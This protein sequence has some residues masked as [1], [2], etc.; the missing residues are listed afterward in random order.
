MNRP[1]VTSDDPGHYKQQQQQ[2]TPTKSSG[3]SGTVITA[4][5]IQPNPQAAQYIAVIEALRQNKEYAGLNE[6]IDYY[7]EYVADASRSLRE[8][9]ALLVKLVSAL[10]PE[11][12][13]LVILRK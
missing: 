2:T 4:P 9:N 8:T 1:R 13:C 6:H 7:L 10:Y 3:G 12:G 11:Q 5:S